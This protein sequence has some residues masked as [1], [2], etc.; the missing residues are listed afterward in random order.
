[1]TA[2]RPDGPMTRRDPRRHSP[3][4]WISSRSG[5]T[6]A[7]GLFSQPG[8]F[9]LYGEPID[10]GGTPLAPTLSVSAG[11]GRRA[12]YLFRVDIGFGGALNQKGIRKCQLQI[13]ASSSF[14]TPINVDV[15]LPRPPNAQW[16]TLHGF[17]RWY[18]R[19]RV[20]NEPA[21]VWSSWSTTRNAIGAFAEEDSGLPGAIRDMNVSA[22]DTANLVSVQ[23]QEPATNSRTIWGYEIQ[24]RDPG[25]SP[26]FAASLPFTL[27]AFATVIASNRVGSFDAGSSVFRVSNS[28]FAVNSE[29]GETL[30]IFASANTATGEVRYPS[31]YPIVSNT[32]DELTLNTSETYGLPNY[33][34]PAGG[35]K[36]SI[37]SSWRTF[38]NFF[39]VFDRAHP[40]AQTPDG[41]V[42]P[43]QQLFN[44]KYPIS[45][46]AVWRVRA[47]NQFGF[48]PWLYWDGSDG[49]T[50][51]TAAAEVTP[52]A[53]SSPGRNHKSSQSPR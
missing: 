51:A 5:T 22:E 47:K 36:W 28:N 12:G 50:S 17:Q 18:F 11:G 33:P 46:T 44:F 16:F 23:F 2:C 45:A 10:L 20:Y 37:F 8:L 4:E 30:Y 42:H 9:S 3:F 13:D 6:G 15:E 27:G 24:A 34:T 32:S 19:A 26:P 21:D 1:M 35:W 40:V 49:S 25:F 38:E 53:G 43:D 14:T 52:T 7:W 31:A 39:E 29:A 48:G 41:P